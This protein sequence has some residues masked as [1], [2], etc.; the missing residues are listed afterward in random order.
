M[1]KFFTTLMEEATD[2]IVST[3]MGASD[4]SASTAT[5]SYVDDNASNA[6][7]EED[8]L[9]FL[10]GSFD[11]TEA[12]EQNTQEDMQNTSTVDNGI[13]LDDLDMSMFGLEN[14]VSQEQQVQPQQVDPNTLLMQ[15]M[16]ERIEALN[17]PQQHQQPTDDEL[18]P[19]RELAERMQQA[20]LLPKGLNEEHE[21]LL[22]EVKSLRDEIKQQKEQQQQ[23]QEFQ[24]KINGIDSFSKELEQVIPNYNSE[25]MINLVAQINAK[26]PRAG[27]QILNNPAMLISLWGKY[28]AKSQPRQQATNVLSTNGNNNNNITS[29]EE[30]FNKVKSGKGTEEDELRLLNGL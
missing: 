1:R 20:G 15:Q 18:A 5:A 28:G 7:T 29:T 17:N 14:A 3:G 22:Q 2:G 13:N 23:L 26:D 24:T 12:Q 25:F 16:M 21:A 10:S 6:L 27:H 4:V 11:Q 30:L 9:S 19:L 8:A